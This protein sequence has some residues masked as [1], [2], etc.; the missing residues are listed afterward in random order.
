VLHPPGQ[1]HSAIC[2]CRS[3][4]GGAST[5]SNHSWGTAIDLAIEGKL[6]DRG[7]NLIQFGLQLISGIF[8]TNGWYWG[9]GFTTEDAQHF[10][11]GSALVQTY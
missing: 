2:R 4:P 1:T 9:A 11:V 5:V 3:N 8:N 10:E 7:N 6:D